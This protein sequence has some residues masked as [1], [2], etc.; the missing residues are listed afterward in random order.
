MNYVS[1]YTPKIMENN[2]TMTSMYAVEGDEVKK[3]HGTIHEIINN[4]FIMTADVNGIQRWERFFN[5]K[6]NALHTLE[7]RRMIV[8]NK[9]LYRPPFTRQRLMEILENVWGKGKYV[10]KLLPDEYKL[11]IDIN[12]NNPVIYLQFSDLLRRIIPANIYLVLSIQYTY[13]YLK[14]NFTYDKLKND[15]YT[16]GELSKYAVSQLDQLDTD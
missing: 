14:R 13:M 12:T 5:I 8:L 11:I 6:P 3:L 16:Y 9:V 15:G 2:D 10:Y 7:E 4:L 1:R